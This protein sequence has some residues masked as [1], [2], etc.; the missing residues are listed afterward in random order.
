MLTPYAQKKYKEAIRKGTISML[1]QYKEEA[2]ERFKSE[3]VTKGGIEDYIEA[4]E[5]HG[6]SYSEYMYQYE[7]WKLSDAQRS[8]FVS[9]MQMI[10]FYRQYIP[11]SKKKMFIDKILFLQ[12]FSSYV[13][14]AWGEWKTLKEDV[15][16]NLHSNYDLI[17]KPIDGNCGQGIFIIPQADKSKDWYSIVKENHMLV[18]QCIEGCDELQKFHPQSLNTI[19]V[20]TVVQDGTP[21]VFHSFFRV[22]SGDSV[23]D[24]AH[25]G[26]MFSQVNI[27]TGILESE[28][29][30]VNGNRYAEHPDTGLTFIG[31][32]IPKWNEIVKTC[33][34]AASI[35][36]GV[37]IVGWDVTILKDGTIELIEGN[38]GPDFDVMQSPLKL[39]IKN[40][41]FKAIRAYYGD[42]NLDLPKE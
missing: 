9:R 21:K 24:N 23:V 27:N 35:L 11:Y 15:F 26:G 38:H 32:Q 30:D 5:K 22:G 12:T 20:V 16:Y 34:T 28:A 29:I 17:A 36:K 18:E 7:F 42:I 33:E 40:K 41:I 1:L 6:V 31:F 4:W 10:S 25:A 8:E 3:S 37:F 39:G 14:R 19:R 13:H 2:I